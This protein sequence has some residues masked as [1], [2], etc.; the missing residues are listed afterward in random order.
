MVHLFLLVLKSR[1]S[2]DY[3]NHIKSYE[4]P[5]LVIFHWCHPQFPSS[6]HWPPAAPSAL[7]AL[8]PDGSGAWARLAG[9]ARPR[10]S[11]RRGGWEPWPGKLWRDQGWL[12]GSLPFIIIG[13]DY[14]ITI[15]FTT[16]WFIII[17][18]IYYGVYHI[19][20]LLL[21]MT[22]IDYC[23][24]WTMNIVLSLIWLKG[25]GHT[26]KLLRYSRKSVMNHICTIILE[27]DN[28]SGKL[29]ESIIQ[30]AL[31]AVSKTSSI[32]VP[33]SET[34]ASRIGESDV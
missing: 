16:L 29:P 17:P 3:C 18:F 2:I 1:F 32:R 7:A 6:S 13:D 5:A 25:H 23:R 28:Q 33:C 4:N 24:E 26:P 8:R 34:F 31:L 12:L 21:G 20:P 19:V 27:G 11:R 22:M 10:W 30:G 15:G 9:W 14:P